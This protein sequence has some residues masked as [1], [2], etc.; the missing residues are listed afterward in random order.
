MRFLR[1][2]KNLPDDVVRNF[3][4]V[5]GFNHVAVVATSLPDAPGLVWG[6]GVGRFVRNEKRPAVA[7]LAITVSDDAQGRGLGHRLALILAAAAQE[8]GVETFEMS[9]LWTNTRAHLLLQRLGAERIGR[10]GEVVDYRIS[11]SKLVAQGLARPATHS[12]ERVVT[13]TPERAAI[14]VK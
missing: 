4:E 7:E 12:L 1:P 11:T 13:S 3:T 8:R 6:Y 14:Y 2:I 10:D 9:V 5:D